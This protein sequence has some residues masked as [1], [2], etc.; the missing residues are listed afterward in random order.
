M[1]KVKCLFLQERVEIGVA[2]QKFDDQFCAPCGHYSTCKV[3]S[4]IED[5]DAPRNEDFKK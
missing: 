5:N 2:A 1:E 3:M 4:P